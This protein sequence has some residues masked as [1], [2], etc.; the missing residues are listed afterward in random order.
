M[1]H[2]RTNRIAQQEWCK[3]QVCP[4]GLIDL[5]GH[6]VKT[7]E[8]ASGASATLCREMEWFRN[9][10]LYF[11]RNTWFHLRWPRGSMPIY[12]N[13]CHRIFL[14]GPPIVGELLGEAGHGFDRKPR[15]DV[16]P[17]CLG[18]LLWNRETPTHRLCQEHHYISFPIT[19]AMPK[20]NKKKMPICW[21]S[22]G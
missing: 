3:F 2:M 5:D 22:P 12:A 14:R 20:L 10:I 16:L 19:S 4:H 21:D 1:I 18:M 8:A 9:N 6:M 13:I 15:Q 17:R 11:V 7:Y